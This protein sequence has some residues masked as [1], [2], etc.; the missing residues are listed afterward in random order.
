MFG[1]ILMS[2]IPKCDKLL[3][4]NVKNYQEVKSDRKIQIQIAILYLII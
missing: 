1:Y 3:K 4:E 2:K